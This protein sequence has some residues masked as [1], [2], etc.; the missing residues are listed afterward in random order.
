VV[1][2]PSGAVY[3]PFAPGAHVSLPRVA[4]HRDGDSTSCPGDAFYHRLPAIR[5]H[6]TALAGTPAQLTIT[7]PTAPVA[8]G[9]TVALSGQLALLTGAPLAGAQIELQQL[10]P[11]GPPAVAIG[12]ATTAAD[13]SW[14]ASVVASERNTI[15]RAVYSAYP[16]AVADWVLVPVA[17]TITLQLL[18]ASPL[19]VSG[20]ISPVAGRVRVFVYSGSVPSGASG[21]VPSGASGSVPSGAPVTRKRV[22]VSAGQFTAQF[23]TVGPGSYVVVARS[24]ETVGNAAGVSA[25]LAVTV[26]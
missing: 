17:P 1:V 22:R 26:T 4:G 6:V 24:K 14:S 20:T 3:T 12:S 5:P 15:V 18:S 13:G 2:D 16:A 7:A 9:S 21:P 8:P 25:P 11:T 10:G 23:P 19:T